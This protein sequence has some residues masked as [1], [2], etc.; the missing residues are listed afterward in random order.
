MGL[1]YFY[2]SYEKRDQVEGAD[3]LLVGQGRVVRKLV[4]ANSGLKVN[5]G[6][7]FPSIKMLSTAS[8]LCSLRLIIIIIT[9][10]QKILT[11]HLAEKLQK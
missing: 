6:K 11:E 2:L 4:N 3:L 5:R 7:N 9:E 1:A 10:G 8:V